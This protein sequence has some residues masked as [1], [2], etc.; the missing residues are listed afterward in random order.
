MALGEA[1]DARVETVEGKFQVIEFGEA[2]IG[3]VAADQ[4]A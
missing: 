3:F 1:L 2:G 4:G